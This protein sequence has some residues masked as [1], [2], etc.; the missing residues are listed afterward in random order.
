MRRRTLVALVV[1]LVASCA[2]YAASSDPAPVLSLERYQAALDRLD[3]HLAAL[4]H[5][6]DGA[7]GV[8][9]SLPL[10]WR[11]QTDQ[12]TFEVST[13]WIRQD[14]GS[15]AQ[16]HD[17]SAL[18]SIRDGLRIMREEAQA[19]Q[20]S[21][22]ETSQSRAALSAILA[23]PEF[24]DVHPP[25][26]LDRLKEAIS[27]WIFRMLSRIL[28]SSSIPTV[29]RVFVYALLGVA[30][31]LLA[32]WVYRRIVDDARLD[33]ILPDVLPVSAKQWRVWMAEARQAA[34]DGRWRD[35]IHLA[36]WAGIS[37]LEENGAWRPDR[38]RTPREYLR[39]VPG[40]SEQF[41]ALSA[42]TRNFE[43]VWY[44]AADADAAAFDKT[45]AE[46]E[47]LGCR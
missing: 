42:L 26:W 4:E 9:E 1:V 29:G 12:K 11:V 46:L 5:N 8:L 32:V 38:A 10:L 15:F 28:G 30:V 44:G 16:K 14:L 39:L 45:L 18:Q 41:G 31:L 22:P 33:D 21:S 43:V 34:Q 6:P 40:T 19:Y 20:G 3:N 7:S 23:R 25:T 2:S 13:E 24:N 35:A 36:Y 17:A 47:K 27:N 37:C